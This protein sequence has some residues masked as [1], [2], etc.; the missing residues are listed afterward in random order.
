MA[1]ENIENAFLIE[2]LWI[3]ENLSGIC[4]FEENYVDFTSEGVSTDL[5]GSFISALLTFAGEAF[6]DEIQHI[7]FSNRKIIFEFSEYLLFIVAV[8]AKTPLADFLIKKKIDQIARAFNAKYQPVFAKDR[9]W[10]G[11]ISQFEPFT[12]DLKKIVKREPLTTKILQLFDFKDNIKKLE[13][14]FDKQVQMA[15]NHKER[16][17]NMLDGLAKKSQLRRMRKLEDKFKLE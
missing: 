3:L 12:E 13:G 1:Q 11:N 14:I 10:G 6:T 9:G 16:L 15:L 2:S 17:E 7:Q 8:N 4:V 5:I